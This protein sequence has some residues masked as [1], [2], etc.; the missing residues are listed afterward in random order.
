MLA[1]ILGFQI[2]G[3]IS[4]EASSETLRKMLRQLEL[5][6]FRLCRDRQDLCTFHMKDIAWMV[7]S[8]PDG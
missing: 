3:M 1:I 4:S 8:L 5:D 6:V 7:R 2:P